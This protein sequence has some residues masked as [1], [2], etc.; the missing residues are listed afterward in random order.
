M[1][2]LAI[3]S[4]AIIMIGDCFISWKFQAQNRRP[5]IVHTMSRQIMLFDAQI[6]NAINVC[7]L[8]LVSHSSCLFDS[9]ILFFFLLFL[10]ST[11]P[12]QLP[13]SNRTLS[14]NLHR[15]RMWK[16]TITFLFLINIKATDIGWFQEIH[17]FQEIQFYQPHQ[18]HIH[19]NI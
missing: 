11:S 6:F 16:I 8:M 7:S 1:Y 14:Y 12:L 5:N 4:N 19:T 15:F 2:A 10:H 18:I 3:I 9:S 13:Y 17:S